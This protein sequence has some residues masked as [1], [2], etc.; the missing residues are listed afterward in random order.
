MDPPTQAHTQKT[1]ML[2]FLPAIAASVFNR[3]QLPH[4][5]L[6][7]TFPEFHVMCLLGTLFRHHKYMHKE[8]KAVHVTLELVNAQSWRWKQHI[9][10]E[11]IHQQLYYFLNF[12]GTL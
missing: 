2:Q 5:M 10:L 1:C 3:C 7:V 6:P 12:K 4:C 8:G 11:R 9:C